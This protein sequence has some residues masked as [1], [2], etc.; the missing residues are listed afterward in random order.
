MTSRIDL[1]QV[2]HRFGRSSN[3][4]DIVFKNDGTV[5]RLHSTIAQEGSEYRLYDEQ[6][7]SGTWVNEQRVPDYGIQLVDG[8]EIRLGAVRLRFRQ[9]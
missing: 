7:T 6:S 8:D 9:P 5:S 3:Q 1:D 4:A 2:E